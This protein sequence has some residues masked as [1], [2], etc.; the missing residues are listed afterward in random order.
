MYCCTAGAMGSH[1]AIVYACIY[2]LFVHPGGWKAPLLW[3]CAHMCY[4][5][6]GFLALSK[7]ACHARIQLYSACNPK[8]SHLALSRPGLLASSLARFSLKYM[9]IY[10]SSEMKLEDSCSNILAFLWSRSS[11]LWCFQQPSIPMTKIIINVSQ[12]ATWYVTCSA[13]N[14]LQDLFFVF[15]FVL[16]FRAITTL[17]SWICNF[18]ISHAGFIL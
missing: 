4:V 17:N 5:V 13:M 18:L 7:L 3:Q 2:F 6:L 10:S 14:G 9:C 16:V 11:L 15:V 12:L 8:V 1:L